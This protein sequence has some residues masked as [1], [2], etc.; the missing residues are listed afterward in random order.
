MNK[1]AFGILFCCLL[2]SSCDVFTSDS[3][4]HQLSDFFGKV[5]VAGGLIEPGQELYLAETKG[6]IF[7]DSTLVRGDAGCAGGH[8]GI[9]WISDDSA[10]VRWNGIPL[11]C[12]EP[13]FFS[14]REDTFKVSASENSIL[15]TSQAGEY[16]LKRITRPP[17]SSSPLIGVW[18]RVWYIDPWFKTRV[19]D[20][21]LTVTYTSTGTRIIKAAYPNG[22]IEYAGWWEQGDGGFLISRTDSSFKSP[23]HF[24]PPK[25]C[26]TPMRSNF[27]RVEGD[28]LFFLD[29]KEKRIG[30][31]RRIY[32]HL[33]FGSSG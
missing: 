1:R 20:P 18:Q 6:L 24:I 15:F 26:Y 23:Q 29:D 31:F 16:F 7:Q 32:P 17:K 22:I 30:A 2:V 27:T 19:Y 21:Y 3:S 9:S 12:G 4:S 28:S 5:L 13:R 25:Y 14:F 33:I 10:S 11:D 8:L